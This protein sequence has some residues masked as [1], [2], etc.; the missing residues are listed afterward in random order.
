MDFEE[1]TQ[2]MGDL[3]EPDVISIVRE[4]ADSGGEGVYEAL[5]AFQKG[6][7]IVGDRFDICEYF[8]GDLIFAGELMTHAVNILRPAL[9]V[10]QP[11]KNT[12]RRVIICTVEGDLHDIGKNIVK[13]VLEGKGIAVID[14]GVNLSP[15]TIVERTI[16]EDI[17]VVALSGVLTYARESM[18]MTVE[19]FA[20][21]GIRDMVKIIVGGSCVNESNFKDIGADAWAASPNASADI[22]CKWLD[23]DKT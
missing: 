19:A 1:L 3:N 4:I 9:Q 7:E 22:C 13:A 11:E 20:N 2:A 5:E 12:K 8:V 15:N 14:L 16:T 18:K 21:A 17:K 23:I 6:M 10:M